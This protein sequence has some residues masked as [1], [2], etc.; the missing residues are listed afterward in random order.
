MIV[1]CNNS[2]RTGTAAGDGRRFSDKHFRCLDPYSNTMRY[3]QFIRFAKAEIKQ[4][5]REIM[6][7]VQSPMSSKFQSRDINSRLLD[8]TVQVLSTPQHTET[9]RQFYPER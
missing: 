2:E 5:F 9:A 7:F 3:T 4:S 8:F 1:W 6:S